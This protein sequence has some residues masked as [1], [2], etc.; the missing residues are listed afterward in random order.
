MNQIKSNQIE[1]SQGLNLPTLSVVLVRPIYPSNIG[2]T[3]RA[4]T[5]FGVDRLVLIDRQCEINS[6]A[7]QAAATGQAPLLN[8]VEYKNWQEFYAQEGEGLKVALTARSGQLRKVQELEPL[9][10][11]VEQT[12]EYKKKRNQHTYFVFGPEDSGLSFDD[13]AF[14]QLC[15]KIPI[16]G[17]NPSLNLSQAVLVTLYAMRQ[18]WGLFENSSSQAE[19]GV[20]QASKTTPTTQVTPTTQATP[21]TQ[22][23]KPHLFPDETI[24]NWITA[25]GFNIEDKK[26]NA[27]TTF[28][29]ML[30][31]NVPTEKELGVFEALLQQ[32]IRKLK[33]LKTYRKKFGTL[34]GLE[35]PLD[36]SDV[37]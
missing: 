14:C 36:K 37:L 8:R 33:Q 17:K 6:K 31:H 34:K 29:R 25:L 7:R 20:N 5:N 18:V 13:L 4:M 12:L 35:P 19:I 27:Y 10:K 15:C 16:Y 22:D 2:A 3:A 24:R 26:I 1:S 23:L 21:T 30:L 11:Q 32:N 28:R 9:L